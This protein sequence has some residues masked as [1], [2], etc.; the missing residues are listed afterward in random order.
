MNDDHEPIQPGDFDNFA[1]NKGEWRRAFDRFALKRGFDP[2]KFY[3]SWQ[4]TEFDITTQER[5]HRK[6]DKDRD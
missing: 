4:A 3:G 5:R 1:G 2:K 6:H